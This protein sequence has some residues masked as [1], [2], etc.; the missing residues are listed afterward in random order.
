M[1]HIIINLSP[2]KKGTSKM[3]T[4]YFID[5]LSSVESVVESLSLYSHLEDMDTVLN[6]IKAADSIIMIG[7]CYVCSFPSD[8]IRL[9]EEMSNTEGTLHSQSIY[10]FIQGGMP[11]VHTHEHGIRL[12]ENFCDIIRI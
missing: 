4:S 7:P 3:L 1:N 11:Y 9:L 10:G 2:R 5:K 12:L 8:T 6:K